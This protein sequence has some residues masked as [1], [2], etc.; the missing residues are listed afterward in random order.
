MNERPKMPE[1]PVGDG[2]TDDTAA[3]QRLVDARPLSA[4]AKGLIEDFRRTTVKSWIEPA[5]RENDNA[6]VAAHRALAEY[7][8]SLE[9]R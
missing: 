9:A 2:V 3:I 8:R 5:S 7:I 1:L 6:W 4:E